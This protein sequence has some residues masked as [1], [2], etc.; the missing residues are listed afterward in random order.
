MNNSV[1]KKLIFKRKFKL[2]CFLLVITFIPIISSINIYAKEEAI[3]IETLSTT[4]TSIVYSGKDLYISPDGFTRSDG[5]S[6]SAAN[7]RNLVC[8]KYNIIGG[9]GHW[10][11]GLESYNIGA[12]IYTSDD[13]VSWTPCS[14]GTVD[15]YVNGAYTKYIGTGSSVYS[16]PP[17]KY[18]KLHITSDQQY[19]S[20]HTYASIEIVAITN[21]LWP[22]F[23]SK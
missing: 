5:T 3:N 9:R 16:I 12:Y 10:K 13:G 6:I 11:G 7:S 2:L 20:V 23:Y 22:I 14:T 8:L 17:A 21:T 18:Y 19:A 4:D 1:K 15:T